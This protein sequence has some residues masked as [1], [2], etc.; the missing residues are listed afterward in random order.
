MPKSR[1]EKIGQETDNI[2]EIEDM[3]I[4][5]EEAIIHKSRVT[6]GDPNK[7]FWKG[8]VKIV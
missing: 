2:K 6:I 5:G 7:G 1:L 4:I 3:T 8:S